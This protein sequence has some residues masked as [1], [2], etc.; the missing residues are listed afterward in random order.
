VRHRPRFVATLGAAIA[1]ALA[2]PVSSTEN[3]T[4]VSITVS[5]LRNE[6]GIV[7]ACLTTVARHFPD[8]SHDPAARHMSVDARNG[9]VLEFADVP[10]GTYAIALLHD[11]NSNGRA[12]RVLMVPREG[13][14]FS[15][16][17]PVR[18]GPPSFESAAF[19]VGTAPVNHTIRM[20]YM[21]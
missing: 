17:A 13:F 19:Q 2:L 5:N 6:R 8:C 15:R 11:E 20:R 1:V 16:D 4:H 3:T 21:L 7:Q 12:D 14:G 10:P 9:M 18:M